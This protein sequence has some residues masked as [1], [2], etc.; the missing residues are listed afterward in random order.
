VGLAR[1]AVIS[2]RCRAAGLYPVA[3]APDHI[4]LATEPVVVRHVLGHLERRG[5]G[6][7]AG[8]WA[9]AVAAPA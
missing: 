3:L 8:P 9:E 5:V 2:P 1:V 7:R 6:A 4:G